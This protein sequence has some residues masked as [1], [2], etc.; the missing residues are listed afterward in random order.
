MDRRTK[1][2]FGIVIL[3]AGGFV[4][5]RIFT[6]L[7]WEPWKKTRDEIREVNQALFRANSTLTD[8]PKVQREW[9]KVR[10]LLNKPRKPDVQN[11]FLEHLGA[12]TD[13]VGATFDFQGSQVQRQGD[14]KEYVVD[15]KL[16]LPW[17]KY[18]DL[19]GEL[20]NSR[21][22]LK[23]IRININSQY[24]KE[25]RMDVDLRVSTIEYDPVAQK[26]GAK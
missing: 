18:V 23:P 2:L 14:F 25:D 19:L 16:K 13:K 17:E 6:S 26:S 12:I 9:K 1:V 22:L 5:D 7:W 8:E 20:H 3:A 4:A 15:F 21:E 11:N 24:E 10:D